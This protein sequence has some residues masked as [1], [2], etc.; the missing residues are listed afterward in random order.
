LIPAA[1]AGVQF[2]PKATIDA[3]GPCGTANQLSTGTLART[4]GWDPTYGM[5][6]HGDSNDDL[7][8]DTFSSPS[9]AANTLLAPYA[10]IPQQISVSGPTRFWLANPATAVFV[11]HYPAAP[12]SQSI[13][14][15]NLTSLTIG[16]DG[17]AY[18][19]D[20]AGKTVYA[21][22]ATAAPVL[23]TAGSFS[24]A[25]S[26]QLTNLA[27]G[28]DGIAYSSDGAS[29]IESLT[30]S[31]QTRS[32]SLPAPGGYLGAIKAVFDGHNGY[33]YAY[34]EDGVNAGT[35]YVFRLSN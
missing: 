20:V 3:N 27:V 14:G 2:I 6:L 29:A 8:T 35:Q 4:L 22:S 5:M 23:Y 13:A 21:Q 31:G 33:L 10:A 26:T 16:P 17:R 11:Q 30:A 9:F 15:T 18:I 24:G 12:A 25:I 19:L 34:Y 1:P 32:V 28:P 7:Y